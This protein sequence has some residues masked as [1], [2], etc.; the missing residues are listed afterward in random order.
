MPKTFKAKTPEKAA[1]EFADHLKKEYGDIVGN[2]LIVRENMVIWEEGP[3]EWTVITM[4]TN[5]FGPEFGNY[6]GEDE[7]YPE[8][9]KNKYV[10]AEAENH[11]SIGFYKT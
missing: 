1:Q 9:P 11:Y 5:M 10:F 4:G 6:S 2:S 7:H 3:Y 8:G